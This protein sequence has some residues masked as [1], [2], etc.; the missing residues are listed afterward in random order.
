SS[1]TPAAIQANR[2]RFAKLTPVAWV[3]SVNCGDVAYRLGPDGA[4][5]ASSANARSV[6]LWKRRA[7][8]FSRHR[9]TM[10]SSDGLIVE[11]VALN[12]GGSSF[13]IAA[14]VSADVSRRNAL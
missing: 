11:L 12:S 7:G 1:R 9:R 6:A 2:S 10:R 4:E 3:V 13:K 5:G 14:M 8:C